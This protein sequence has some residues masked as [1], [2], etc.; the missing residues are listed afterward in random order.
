MKIIQQNHLKHFW[1]M[2][3][4]LLN[5]RTVS[6]KHDMRIQIKK[7]NNNM[8][9]N[10]PFQSFCDLRKRVKMGAIVLGIYSNDGTVI[11][12][13]CMQSKG[14]RGDYFYI[15]KC[16]IYI[17]DLFIYSEYRGNGFMGEFLEY[18][19]SKKGKY[20]LCV[21]SNN[22]S[23]IICYKKKGFNIID[24]KRVFRLYKDISFPI[25]SI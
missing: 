14:Q 2:E 16:D 24:N 12:F 10:F 22:E 19:T 13:G 3:Y 18:I 11:G 7:L 8:I 17:S 21:R 20:R 6:T 4:N 5:D 1:I 15:R 23:A 25:Y 9:I